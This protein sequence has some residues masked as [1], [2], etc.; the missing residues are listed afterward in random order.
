MIAPMSMAKTKPPASRRPPNTWSAPSFA[1]PTSHSTPAPMP[2]T[3]R[4]TKSLGS[5]MS[6]TAASTA[7][8]PANAIPLRAR[9]LNTTHTNATRSPSTTQM[10]GTK[11]PWISVV[12]NPSKPRPRAAGSQYP[13]I[14]RRKPATR[15][16]AQ[17]AAAAVRSPG[18]QSARTMK[19]ASQTC[20]PMPTATSRHGTFRRALLHA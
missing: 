1:N 9:G 14:S 7:R 10:F 13:G 5:S 3:A 17:I 15:I 12:S 4:K 18:T 8:H 20:S 6:Q 16:S 2:S 11:T 19:S